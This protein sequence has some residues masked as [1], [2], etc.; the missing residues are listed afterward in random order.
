MRACDSPTFHGPAETTPVGWRRA[1][2]EVDGAD[3]EAF[4]REQARDLA[5][6]HTAADGG[7][8]GAEVDV[9]QHQGVIPKDVVGHLQRCP[10]EKI[11]ALLPLC[12]S[13]PA[14]GGIRPQKPLLT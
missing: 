3:A 4:P 7:D 11:A 12:A 10:R 5:L 13:L 1:C 6:V 8:A 2:A 14:P 9:A